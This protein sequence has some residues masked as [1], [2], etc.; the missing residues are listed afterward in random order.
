MEH[1]ILL[2]NGVKYNLDDPNYI[3]LKKLLNSIIM[4]Q[5]REI[6]ILKSLE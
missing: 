1:K 6:N 4:T 2:E 3:E 5:E